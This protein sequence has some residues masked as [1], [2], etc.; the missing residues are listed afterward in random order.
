MPPMP[1]ITQ[2]LML[3]NTGVF[4]AL[5]L[6]DS[7]FG[8]LFALWP[9]GSGFLPWQ[10]VTYAFVHVSMIQ[11]F[12]NML[13]LWMFGAEMERLWGPKRYLQFYAAAIITGAFVQLGASALFGSMNPA[14][15]ATAALFGLLM[16]FGLLFPNRTIMPLFPPIPMKARVF[17]IV[18]G[19]I[20]LLVTYLE[21]RGGIVQFSALGGMIG[22]FLMIQYWRGRPPFGSRR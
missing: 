22:G 10:V 20:Q 8:R 11:L 6:F 15:G 4:C 12:F 16:A 7:W 5:F 14:T 9:W 3:I 21:Q 19:G 17:V 2:A 18:F 13:G 1:P